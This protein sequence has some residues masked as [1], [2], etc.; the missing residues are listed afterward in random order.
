[1]KHHFAR[2]GM[3][4]LSFCLG[5]VLVPAQPAPPI[6]MVSPPTIHNPNPLN[7]DDWLEQGDRFQEKREFEKAFDAYRHSL[8]LNQS[9]HDTYSEAYTLYTIG[10]LHLRLEQ[11]EQGLPV[12]QQS[13]L[14]YQSLNE[15]DPSDLEWVTGLHDLLGRAYRENKEPEKAELEYKQ[16]LAGYRQLE[17]AAST[18]EVLYQLGRLPCSENHPQEHIGYLKEALSIF[19]QTE[20]RRDQGYTWL[21]LGMV[22]QG[23]R[24]EPAALDCFARSA[25]IFRELHRT[26]NEADCFYWSGWSYERMGKTQQAIESFQK[27]QTLFQKA[28]QPEW[29][30]SAWDS[31]G[32]NYRILKDF[33][34]AAESY[35]KA[36]ELYEQAGN[37]T[38][39]EQARRKAE[40]LNHS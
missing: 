26:S 24:H 38:D 19:R 2:F 16:A 4:F 3:W 31:I 39:G 27:A 8:A 17:D 33:H 25:Q 32:F 10:H 29:E 13:W 36:A 15:S 23:S 28:N 22:H 40:I 11:F 9:Q 30:G 21:E 14:L 1:M 37:Q 12:L 18:G 35:T 7:A 20:N 6:R 5:I 34:K